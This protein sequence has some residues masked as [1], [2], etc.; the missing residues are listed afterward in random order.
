VRAQG[1]DKMDGRVLTCRTLTQCKSQVDA[2]VASFLNISFGI[3]H[4]K[5]SLNM[6]PQ[7]SSTQLL[8]WSLAL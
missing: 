2:C 3:Q 7:C 6:Y 5:A 4:L 8:Q 1:D